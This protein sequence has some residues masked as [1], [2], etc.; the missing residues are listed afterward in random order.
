MSRKIKFGIIGCGR[1]GEKL[2][3]PAFKDSKKA[4]LIAITKRDL[5]AALEKARKYEIPL[6]YS[7]ENI[8]QMLANLEIEVVYITSPN[9]FHHK[10]AI[11]ALLAG[12]HVIVEKPMALNA[13]QCKEMISTAEQADRKLMVAHCFR[14]TSSIEYIKKILDDGKLGN[15]VMITADF[16]TTGRASTRSW[17]YNKDLSG[18]GASFDLAVHMIDII[19][20]LNPVPIKD[21]SHVH[22]PDP[23]PE[24]YLDEFATFTLRF[25][26]GVVGR[27]TGSFFGPHHTCLEVYGTDG[28]IRA[29]DWHL[30]WRKVEIIKEIGGKPQ[31]YEVKNDDNY[32][33]QID[34]FAESI[35]DN[36]PVPISGEEGLI[37][38]KI[39][40][41]VNK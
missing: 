40:D 13:A 17:K 25:E 33:L 20:Y 34:A 35:L 5:G 22:W 38:Q 8:P 26:N 2:L 9:K 21:A 27:A 29:F 10:D 15:P 11:A 18:G 3:I 28:F 4:E 39:I 12:K 41:E 23:L 30:P 16:M 36:T 1:F 37:N 31:T 14:F 24:G 32:R 6:A 19:R 7:S